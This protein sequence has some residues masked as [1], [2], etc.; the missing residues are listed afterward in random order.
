MQVLVVGSG[1]IGGYFGSI[2]A[3]AG[4]DVTMLVRPKHR[5]QIRRGGFRIIGGP[6]AGTAKV[7]TVSYLA[8]AGTPDLVL[9][10]VKSYDTE[11][12]ARPLRTVLG[13]SSVV[14]ELQNGVDRAEAIE[15]IVGKGHVLA[16][17][18]YLESVLDGPGAVR[19]L[20]G[21]RRIVFGEIGAGR[22]E[23][24]DALRETLVQAGINAETPDEIR[25]ALWH[26]YIL[27]CA[28][29]GLTALTKAPFGDIVAFPPGR[30]LVADVLREAVAV[31]RALGIELGHDY[32]EKSL[33]FLEDMG[34][35]LRSSMLRDI[36]LD[37]RTEVEAIHGY[38]VRQSIGLG[39][40]VPLTRLIW[41]AL[42]LHNQR[43]TG[44]GKA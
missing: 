10:A 8:A 44:G 41:L 16:G 17:T 20:S 32:V 14:L 36:E 38:L 26:K 37:R 9:F 1:A 11:E 21:A 18:V 23:R 4:H 40:P 3:R 5:D 42:T 39:V 15:A 19:Y 12:V 34:P 43:V 31:G 30:D 13:K 2:L 25:P 33:A 29:N 22:S 6:D 35:K 7:E 27:V 28:A 24:V